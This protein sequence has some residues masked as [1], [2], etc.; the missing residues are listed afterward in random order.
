MILPAFYG[1]LKQPLINLGLDLRKIF[2][3]FLKKSIKDEK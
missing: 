3:T 1:E 2:I